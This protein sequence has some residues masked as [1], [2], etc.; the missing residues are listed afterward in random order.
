MTNATIALSPAF[1]DGDPVV[2]RVG[3]NQGTTGVFLRL[4]DDVK[5]ADIVES[6][7][8]VRSHPLEWLA[9]RPARVVFEL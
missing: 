5:W 7:G 2:L 6:N 4:K 9:H 1:K 8:A 3:S